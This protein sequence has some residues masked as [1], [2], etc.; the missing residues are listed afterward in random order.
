MLAKIAAYTEA[1]RP[2]TRLN[3]LNAMSN[4]HR[5]TTAA[6]AMASVVDH[7]LADVPCAAVFVPTNT[8]ATARMISRFSPPVW[9]VAL[10]R[11]AAVCQGLAFSYGV[12]PVQLARDPENWR[13]FVRE[14]LSEHQVP[15]AL[16]MLAAGPSTRSPDDNHRIEIVRVGDRLCR[17][18]DITSTSEMT[19][20]STEREHH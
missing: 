6:E 11:D 15:G 12:H 17:P 7:A 13:D 14:W 8:G 2:P 20:G 19:G 9:I 16:A 1:H 4:L 3:D 10:S 18:S 5:P